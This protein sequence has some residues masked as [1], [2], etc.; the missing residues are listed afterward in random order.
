MQMIH[1]VWSSDGGTGVKESGWNE[2]DT[3]WLFL[4][5]Q[6]AAAGRQA[7]MAEGKQPPTI[8]LVSLG[9]IWATLS[10]V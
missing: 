1:L 8:S 6:Q 7:K 10:Q 9:K 5:R 3:K 4:T 2:P